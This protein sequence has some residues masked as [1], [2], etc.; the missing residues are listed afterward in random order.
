MLWTARSMRLSSSASSISFVN[1]PFAADFVQGHVQ[2]LVA[3]GLDDFDAAFDAR[4]L[5]DVL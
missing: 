3:R 2:D 4:G 1:E 5:P